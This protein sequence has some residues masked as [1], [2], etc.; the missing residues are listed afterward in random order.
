MISG[1]AIPAACSHRG[2]LW[3]AL[4]GVGASVA[5][6]VLDG[7]DL[8]FDL[9]TYHYYLGHTAFVDRSGLDFL[10][11]S[12][13]GYQSPLPYALLVLL[14]GIGTPPVINAALHAG[15]HALNLIVLFFLTRL[16][17]AET[18]TAPSRAALLSFWLL[19]AIAPVYWQLVGT[20]FADLMTSLLVL[21]GLWLIAASLQVQSGSPR[22][23]LRA[24]VVGGVLAGAAVGLRVHNAIYV[25]AL[26]VA[27]LALRFPAGAAKGR[28]IAAFVPA[29]AGGWFAFFAPWGWRNFREFGNPVFP[30]FNGLF[31]SPDFPAANLPLT[32]FVPD[33][34]AGLVAFPFRIGTYASWVYV[35]SPLP[36]VRP[37]LLVACVLAYG[38]YRAV[39]RWVL[40]PAEDA[41]PPGA[42]SFIMLFFF[43]S[44]VLWLATS[45]NGRYGVALFL[46]AGPVCGVLLHRMLR[47]RFVLLV[48]GVTVIWQVAVQQVLFGLPRWG[49]SAWGTRYFDW[50]IPE[51]M[52]R[53]PAVYLSFGYQTASTLVPR[54]HPDSRHVNLV[55]Q[56]AFGIDDP[57]SQRIRRIIDAPGRR[58]YGIFDFQ[59]TQQSDPAA[60]SIK[61]Y[62]AEHLHLW[63]LGFVD[64]P[65]TR[66]PLKP[67]PGDW[68]WLN[69]FAGIRYRG[70]RPE[71]I[72]CELQASA[73]P[74]R[75][76]ARLELRNF[77]AGLAPLAAACP[78][79]F[80]K[81]LSIV[82]HPGLWI[83]ASLATF[84]YRIEFYDEGAF[85]LQQMRPPYATVALGTVARGVITSQEIKCDAWFARARS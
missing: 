32:S 15:I 2:W 7:Q 33:S 43:A 5:R 47:L 80:G 58:I 52:A 64:R 23:A 50:D 83:V 28:V 35:E 72:L 45:C 76:R 82:R 9:V 48:I 49:A 68:N 12:F 65:C 1:R 30:F 84:E 42:R 51:Q 31:R 78:L 57:G 81:P 20:S 59:Y 29:A 62:F 66:V 79:F 22:V 21:S 8:N 11:A 39:R 70:A 13:Q 16:L 36:D 4:L 75:E 44:A 17:I 60:R 41:A 27:L 56:Y 6:T 74:D 46:L 53:E 85:Y 67:V 14:D 77:R 71:F 26:A 10:P 69:R 40:R 61:T 24:I 37:G 19:G 54:L 55:G 34:L 38:L 63:G 3:V 73:A 18:A 25:V